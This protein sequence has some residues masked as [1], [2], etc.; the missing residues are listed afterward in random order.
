MMKRRWKKMREL[1]FGKDVAVIENLARS[2]FFFCIH[3]L[4]QVVRNWFSSIC[5][6][7]TCFNYGSFGGFYWVISRHIFGLFWQLPV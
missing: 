2:F 6:L 5:F 4:M 1:L 7:Y 3:I